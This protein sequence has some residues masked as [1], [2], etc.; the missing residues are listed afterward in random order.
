MK[1]DKMAKNNHENEIQARQDLID[2][3]HY[4]E[5][6]FMELEE[7]GESCVERLFF[8]R[9]GEEIEARAESESQ[10]GHEVSDYNR[11]MKY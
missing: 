1:N 6:H 7:M 3:F 2:E 10:Y 11:D 4:T 8:E 5:E 9:R